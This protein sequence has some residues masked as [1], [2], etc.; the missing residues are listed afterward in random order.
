MNSVSIPR[1]PAARAVSAAV[2]ISADVASWVAETV[3]IAEIYR[4]IPRPAD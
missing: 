4:A 1:R 2:R 3:S